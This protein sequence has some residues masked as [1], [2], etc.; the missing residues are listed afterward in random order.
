M[1]KGNRYGLG[2]GS[3][4]PAGRALTE[5]NGV[6]PKAASALEAAGITTLEALT[7]ADAD[8]LA[9][10]SGLSAAKISEWQR[11]AREM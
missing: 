6:G 9:E 8:A 10:Q 1:S 3:A 2:G 7:D 5:I 4:S 11:L